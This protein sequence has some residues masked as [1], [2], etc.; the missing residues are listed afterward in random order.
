MSSALRSLKGGSLLPK[1]LV[2]V[3]IIGIFFQ[4][5][6]SSSSSSTPAAIEDETSTPPEYFNDKPAKA[7]AHAET[8]KPTPAA[9][10]DAH[11]YSKTF[12]S[13]GP[14]KCLP[15]FTDKMKAA[16]IERNHTCAKYAPFTVQESRRVA[17]AGITTGKPVEAYQRAIAS[18]M[19]AAAVQGTSAHILCD[20]LFDSTWNKIAFLLNLVMNEMLKPANERLEWIMWID[21]DA[22]ILDPCRPLSSFLPPNTPDFDD[23]NLITNNDALGLNNGVFLF[24]VSDWATNYFN[25]VLAFRYF[26]PDEQLTQAEQSG[27]DRIM[28]ED[29]FKK[30][31]VRVPWYWFNAYPD[32]D[33]SV[34]KYREGRETE[35]LEWFRARKG[36]YVV[37]FAGDDGRSGRMPD[38]ENM[39][40]EV[41]NVYE[42]KEQQRDVT[43]EV[44][45]YWQ[46][47]KAGSLTEHQI[48]GEKWRE[49]NV[50]GKNKKEG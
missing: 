30:G 1:I 11:D 29:K 15:E 20:Q 8:P 16:A 9:A 39:I 43:K 7:S 36:D 18:Q 45:K 49:E 19:F 17:F 12:V 31:F 46:S 26:R 41:G 2:G 38:W 24:K 21:R 32:E 42:K 28:H 5:Q 14:T 10:S 48:T 44:E 35:D 33:D 47:W 50:E 13:Y 3:L 37:H 22:I 34:N 4:L 23:V 27:M 6:W 25:A 40:E